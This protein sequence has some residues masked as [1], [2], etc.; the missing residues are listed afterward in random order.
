MPEEREVKV[1]KEENQSTA[2]G[3]IVDT[4]E[5]LE[6]VIPSMNVALPVQPQEPEET[7]ITDE[8]LLGIYG[9]IMTNLRDDREEISTLLTNFVEMVINEGDSTTS[10]KEAVV[11]LAKIK[12]ETADKMAKVA[13][14][15]TRVKLKDK[16]T[17]PRYLAAKQENNLYIGNNTTNKREFLK[18]LERH[19]KKKKE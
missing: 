16:D 3:L 13:D 14:L 11:N 5:E 2:D 17:F 7:L 12:S 10:S 15:M 6:S 18:Q 4:T 19:Q 1:N 8:A 9:E